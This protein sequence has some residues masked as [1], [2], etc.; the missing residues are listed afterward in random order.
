MDFGELIR[1]LGEFVNSSN[2]R[3]GGF[4]ARSFLYSRISSF[5]FPVPVA[6]CLDLNLNALQAD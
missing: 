5:S 4:A 2:K 6:G 1:R 3:T